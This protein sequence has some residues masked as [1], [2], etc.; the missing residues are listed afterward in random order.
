MFPNRFSPSGGTR[1]AVVFF[2]EVEVY[3]LLDKVDFADADVDGVAE[4]VGAAVA[5]ADD[6]VV[7]LVE[8]VVVVLETA[9]GYHALTFVSLDFGVDAPLTDAAD[10][11]GEDLPEFVGQKFGLLVFH[12]GAFSICGFLFHDG[13]VLA[14]VLVFVGL[15]R[16]SSLEITLQKPM[17]HQVGVAADGGGEVGVVG[18]GEAVVAD[19]LGA[20]V[21][22]GHGA[23]GDGVDHVLLA[24]AGDILEETVVALGQRLAA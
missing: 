12:A 13:A 10:E 15:D 16:V 17:H 22:L 8:H 6:L 24:T 23:D 3:L 9:D 4:L 19:I 7:V 1:D 14:V 21:G 18:E 2:D 11:G 5:A 20:V